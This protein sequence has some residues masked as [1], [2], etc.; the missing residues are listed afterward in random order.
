[1]QYYG[2]LIYYTHVSVCMH[3][4]ICELPEI[5]LKIASDKELIKQMLSVM[6]CPSYGDNVADRVVMILL[7][8]SYSFETH[9]QLIS[10]NEFAETIKNGTATQFVSN[11]V[12]DLLR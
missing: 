1:M 10:H 11:E 8:L 7:V 3:C 2:H 9:S 4:S 5:R 12:Q 6:L